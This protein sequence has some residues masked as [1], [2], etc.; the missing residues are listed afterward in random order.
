MVIAILMESEMRLPEELLEAIIN[1]VQYVWSSLS[2]N[3]VILE[4]LSLIIYICRHLLMPMLT[5]TVRS[6]R[7]NG[8]HSWCR[9]RH[10]WGTWRFLTWGRIWDYL[11]FVLYFLLVDG[12]Y[13]WFFSNALLMP[14]LVHSWD[15]VG[16]YMIWIIIICWYSR[17]ITT[18]FPSFIFNTE[19]EE[20]T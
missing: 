12:K 18:V 7:K 2:C 13:D 9:T 3:I 6:T 20:W 8:K 15:S 5:W 17:D 4:R 11:P 14:L 19:V 10:C 1:K 16:G